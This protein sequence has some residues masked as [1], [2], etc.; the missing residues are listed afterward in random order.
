M[1][2][3]YSLISGMLAGTPTWLLV[4][5][6]AAIP[7]VVLVTFMAV[8]PIAYVYAETKIAG[9]MQDRI[10]PKRVGPHGLLQTVA[11]AVKLLF[12]EAIYPKGAD[13]FLF[14]LAPCLVCVGAF[15]PFVVVPWGGRMQTA[16]LNVGVFYVVAVASLSTVGIIMAGW[17][18]NN[19]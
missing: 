16:D 17:A 18:S 13:K 9:F 7:A 15:L 10:G 5:L 14:V 2:F 12:K 3:T 6:S 8:G 11:D 19:K 4:A 1:D